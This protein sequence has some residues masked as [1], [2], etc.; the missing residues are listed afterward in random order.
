MRNT[1]QFTTGRAPQHQ[2]IASNAAGDGG[3]NSN[4]TTSN[5][6]AVARSRNEATTLPP[7][8]KR[9]VNSDMPKTANAESRKAK[10]IS[11]SNVKHCCRYPIRD[12]RGLLLLSFP[13]KLHLI[14]QRCEADRVER[15]NNLKQLQKG[16]ECRCK[17]SSDDSRDELGN[18]DVIIG[19]LS[20][21]TAFK[22]YDEERF[23]REVMPS[24]FFEQ[25]NNKHSFETFQ[26]NLDMWGFSSVPF[27]EGPSTRNVH[28]CSHP[29]FLKGRPS[30]CQKMKFR[31]QP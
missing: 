19:W 23:V 18:D 7:S 28:V 3:E 20:S 17:A 4:G 1:M 12:Q 9:R 6:N 10:R 16:E 29:F 13:L 31:I 25:D 11:V 15:R 21:G 27:I 22:I 5:D 2:Q 30:A 8:K 24:Y 26:R 14:L